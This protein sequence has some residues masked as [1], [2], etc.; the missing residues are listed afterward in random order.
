MTVRAFGLALAAAM[1]PLASPA[2]AMSCNTGPYV[3]FFDE[4]SDRITQ[5]GQRILDMVVEARRNCGVALAQ[6]G[7]HIDA[8]EDLDLD[9]RRVGAVRAFLIAQGMPEGEMQP[10]TF[11]ATTPRKPNVC[12]ADEPENRRVEITFAPMPER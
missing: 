6:I 8:G 1:L 10:E 9:S 4:G 12:G 2:S 7:G 11:D 5:D 3:V